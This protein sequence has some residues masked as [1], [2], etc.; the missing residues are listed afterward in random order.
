M[1]SLTVEGHQELQ[2]KAK[3]AAVAQNISLSPQ[4]VGIQQF[5]AKVS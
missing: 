5:L 3:T 1:D 2:K 4:E